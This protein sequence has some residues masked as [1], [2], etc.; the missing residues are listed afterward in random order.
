[1]PC[2][3][4]TVQSNLCYIV[5][6]DPAAG[7]ERKRG[8]RQKER[9]VLSQILSGGINTEMLVSWQRGLADWPVGTGDWGHATETLAKP[10]PLSASALATP[11]AQSCLLNS[12]QNYCPNN[13]PTSECAQ[14]RDQ[15]VIVELLLSC[16]MSVFGWCQEYRNIVIF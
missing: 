10:L 11:E 12:D 13:T 6:K 2:Q 1:M 5:T 9:N 15:D 16:V 8:D 7:V 14:S 4:A 3:P